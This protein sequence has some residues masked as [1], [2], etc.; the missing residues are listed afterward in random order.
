MNLAPMPKCST[1]CGNQVFERLWQLPS[2]SLVVALSPPSSSASQQSPRK[3]SVSAPGDSS[4]TPSPYRTRG[5]FFIASGLGLLSTLSSSFP[6]PHFGKG[7]NR[8]LPL[9]ISLM[10]LEIVSWCRRNTPAHIDE[11][12]SYAC[13]E[14]V[15]VKYQC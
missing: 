13:C 15:D 14:S 4:A 1:G 11:I 2:Y 10:S 8:V 9:E 6:R 5:S 12:V 7:S 3:A